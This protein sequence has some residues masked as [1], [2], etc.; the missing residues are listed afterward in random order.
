M[1]KERKRKGKRT[2]E[3]IDLFEKIERVGRKIKRERE[4]ERECEKMERKKRKDVRVFHFT[5]PFY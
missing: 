1:E 5:M 3:L 2:R 4:R